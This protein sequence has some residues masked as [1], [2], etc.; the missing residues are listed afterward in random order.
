M[1][2]LLR[3]RD[4]ARVSR[5][6]SV[7]VAV[8]L[9]DIRIE[10]RGQGDGRRVGAATTERGDV[11]GVA[12]E[13]LEPGDDD[14]R[15]LVEG[16]AQADGRDVDDA[17]RAVLRVGDHSGLAAG[18]RTRL[19]AHRVDGHGEQRHRDALTAR[20]QHVELARG[21]DRRDLVGEIEQLVGRV[22]HRAHGDDDV[23]PRSSRVHDALGD[24]LDALCVGD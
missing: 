15:P 3:L 2:E 17:R 23:V 12:V 7:D 14:D 9:A 24:A 20:E 5:E 6:D 19:E 21:G 4:D 1:V 13:A 22:A 18:E 16:F 11:A 10:G 8:D